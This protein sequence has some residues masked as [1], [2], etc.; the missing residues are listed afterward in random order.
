MKQNAK[1][2]ASGDVALFLLRRSDKDLLSL[3]AEVKM[4]SVPSLSLV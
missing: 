1:L 2:S 3:Q 4:L